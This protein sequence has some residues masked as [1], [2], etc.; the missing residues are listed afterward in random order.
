MYINYNPNPAGRTVGDC[1][2]R[3]LAKALD[4]TWEDA[5]ILAV[6]NGYKMADK[7]LIYTG[8]SGKL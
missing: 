1:A 7:G 6:T 4:I 8:F 3:A 5:Y 2:I